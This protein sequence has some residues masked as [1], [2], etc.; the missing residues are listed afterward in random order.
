MFSKSVIALQVL[1]ATLISTGIGVIFVP[2]GIVVAGVF[3]VL[4]G[5]ALE[6]RNAR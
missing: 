3:S 2:A 5:L 6:R 1:G 4:F